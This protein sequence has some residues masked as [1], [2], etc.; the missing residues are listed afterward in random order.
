MPLKKKAPGEYA[1]RTRPEHSPQSLRHTWGE[2]AFSGLPEDLPDGQQ[3][4]SGQQASSPPRPSP[5]SP[6][7]SEAGAPSFSARK[8]L[9][10][11]LA[12]SALHCAQGPGYHP[13]HVTYPRAPWGQTS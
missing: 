6:I 5:G 3:G 1:R 13:A 11:S 10:E 8:Q 2:K 7:Q 4:A 12:E 9:Q